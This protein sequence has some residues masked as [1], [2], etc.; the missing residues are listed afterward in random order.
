[1]KTNSL[2]HLFS[3]LFLL[4]GFV[5][6]GQK[7]EKIAFHKADE[8]FLYGK[9]MP[10]KRLYDR[11]DTVS[12]QGLP[13]AV[14]RLLTNSAGLAVCFKTNSTIISAKWCVTRS[15]AASNLT[16]I[17][18][19]GLDLYIK[20]DGK[21]QFAGVG[22][23]SDVC[24]EAVLVKN[25]DKTE[26]ECILYLP[27]YDAVSNIE[28]GVEDGAAIQT[29]DNPFR[30]KIV[31][32]GSSILQGAA[33]SRPGM[34]YPAMLS[35][36]TGLGFYNLGVSGS[37]KMEKEAADLLTDITADAIILDCIPNPSPEQIKERSDYF[38]K[39]VR[40]SHPGIPLIIIQSVVREHGYFDQEV[41][42]RVKLQNEL[43]AE[44]YNKLKKEGM[45]DVYFI[46]SENFLGNDHE[47][48]VDGTHPSDLGFFRMTEQLKPQI[49]N[50]LQKYG[51]K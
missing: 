51:I 47:A 5:V 46:S 7:T 48:T 37:A 28:I 50:I 49:L 8:F 25:M 41:G 45:K 26:K 33:A 38:I 16:P 35:R 4:S 40:N 12:Y 1:M 3:V 34:I 10:T 14:K 18:N 19:K 21:W 23:P 24:S 27:L 9:V 2:K 17:A 42:K 15:K 13:A 32:Y 20:K 30:K 44:E 6:M 22:K 39:T 31:I 43:I 36:Q 11:I 29:V